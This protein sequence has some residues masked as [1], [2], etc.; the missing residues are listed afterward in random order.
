MTV[1]QLYNA[2]V[3]LEDGNMPVCRADNEDIDTDISEVEIVTNLEW[4]D[5]QRVPVKHVRLS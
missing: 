2:L 5:G 1:Q 3:K 4:H